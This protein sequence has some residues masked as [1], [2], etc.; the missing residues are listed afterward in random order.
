MESTP[1]SRLICLKNKEDKTILLEQYRI[2]L[3]SIHKLN[4]IRETANNFWIGINGAL[5]ATIAYVRDAKGACGDQ[6]LFFLFTIVLL[7]FFLTSFWLSSLI[8][9]KNNIDIKNKLTAEIEE[10]LP[11]KIFTVTMKQKTGQ[12]E[13]W[14]ALALKEM[15]VPLTFLLEYVIFAIFLWTTPTAI[16]PS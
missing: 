15:F 12:K 4:D 7:G 6:K 2:L 8:S 3:E 10:Y 9:I 13:N 16:L 5:V 1:I 11:A 14:S